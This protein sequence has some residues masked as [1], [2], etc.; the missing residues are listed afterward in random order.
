MSLLGFPLYD[1][2]NESD[3]EQKFLYPLLNHPQFL[4]IPSRCILTKKSLRAFSFVSKASLP[5]DYVPD[6]L[7]FLFGFPVLVIEAKSPLMGANVAIAEARLYAHVLNE[8]FPS[9]TNPVFLVCG[10]NG[11]EFL[12]GSWDSAA[13]EQFSCTSLLIGSDHL[14][15]LRQIMGAAALQHKGNRIHRTLTRTSLLRPARQLESQLF[16]DRVRPNALAPY[17]NPIYEM[18]FR[19]EEPEKIQLILEKAYV[20]TA[21]LRE[22]DHVLHAMLRQIERTHTQTQTIQTELVR[23]RRWPAV[24][25][26]RSLPDCRGRHR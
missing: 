8:N 5:R 23:P 21:E 6:Y 13:H 1:C 4:A 19:A 14:D 11:R 18:F 17:L 22:Y 15:R 3:V 16:L 26:C 25:V 9:G 20:D 12:V 2:S 24:A 7:V 10:C